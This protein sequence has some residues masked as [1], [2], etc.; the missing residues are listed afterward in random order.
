MQNEI[1]LG[2]PTFDWLGLA[3]VIAVIVGG[4]LALMLE[5]ARPKSSNRGV[6]GVSLASLAVAGWFAVTSIGQPAQESMGGQV[7]RDGPG[8]IIQLLIIAVTALT[9]TFSDAYLRRR[10]IAFGEFYP[11]ALWAASGAMVMATTRDLLMLFLGLEIMS[12]SLY[13]LAGLS[14]KERRSEE[15]SLKY[16]LLGAFASAF[17]LLGIAFLFG[18]SGSLHLS[19][20]P[21]SLGSPDPTMARF[22]EFGLILVIAGLF[23]KLA[24]FP[25]HQWTPDVY[26]GAPT[27]VTAFM[28]ALV[29]PAT[30]IFLYR[31][32]EASLVARDLWM[33]IIF[34][35]AILTMTVGNLS[36]LV[37]KDAK[38]TLAYSSIAHAGYLLVGLAAWAASPEKI[39][40]NAILFYLVSYGITTIGIFATMT[41]LA[42]TTREDT[43]LSALNGLWR[44]S[45]WTAA[46][47]VV[48]AASL[49]GMP[50]FAGFWAKILILQDAFTAEQT[51]LALVLIVNSII[52]AIYYVNMGRE[53]FVEDEPEPMFTENPPARTA[54]GSLGLQ[55][56][57]AICAGLT[58]VGALLIPTLFQSFEATKMVDSSVEQAPLTPPDEAWPEKPEPVAKQ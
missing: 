54:Q 15:A 17:L 10:G 45:P 24:V 12:I 6:V 21:G 14:T 56:T 43:R 52:S 40:P 36:A 8:L 57:V 4:L 44:R 51:T 34:W 1:V 16:L 55:V 13:C 25:F 5:M 29:K 47:M 23:F 22:A 28:A 30:L 9:V 49:L 38:R 20:L 48:F 53:V 26:Q 3:P 50:I 37:S 27:N 35:G 33:P 39:T 46:A 11:L 58:I 7:V 19:A 2:Y 18:A 41:L 42:T 31:L 32:L